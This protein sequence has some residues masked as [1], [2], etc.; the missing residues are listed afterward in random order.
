MPSC[1][2]VPKSTSH[3]HLWGS[4]TTGKLALVGIGRGEYSSVS[5]LYNRMLQAES[6][7]RL[8]PHSI[9]SYGITRHWIICHGVTCSLLQ[10]K[11]CSQGPSPLPGRFL[12]CVSACRKIYPDL[13]RLSWV[14]D[15]SSLIWCCK[16]RR[17]HC[18]RPWEVL[19]SGS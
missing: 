12:C 14:R 9:T 13:L 11:C 5:L 6:H 18:C 15:A 8:E 17:G 4:F 10:L 19:G 1:V 3:T 2:N 16:H 7:S